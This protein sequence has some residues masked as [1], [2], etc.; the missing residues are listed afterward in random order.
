MKNFLLGLLIFFGFSANAQCVDPDLIDPLAI[1]PFIF[2]PVCGCDGNTYSNSCVAQATGGVTSWV[3]GECVAGGGCID[4]SL[5]DPDAI[6]IGVFAPVCGCDGITYSNSCWA[7]VTGGNTSWTDG[8]CDGGGSGCIDETLINP[9]ADCPQI[10]SKVCGCDDV[11]YTNSCWAQATGG[12]TQFAPGACAGSTGFDDCTDLTGLDF[13]VCGAIL[14][15]GIVEGTCT[16]ISGCSYVS[17]Q[18]D[19]AGAFYNTMEDCVFACGDGCFDESLINENAVCNGFDPVCGCDNVTYINAC[20]AENYGGLQSWTEGACSCPDPEVID[21]TSPCITIYDPV[22]GCNG[23][24]YDNDCDAWYGFGITEW[25]Q[26]ACEAGC[27]DIGDIDFGECD[28]PLGIMW[29]GQDCTMLSGCDWTVD[30]VD[31]SPYFFDSLAE[32][33]SACGDTLC[34]DPSIIDPTIICNTVV[35]PVCGCDSVTYSNACAAMNWYGVLQWTEGP[36]DTTKM[37]CIDPDLIDPLVLC[38]DFFEPV[39]GCDSMLYQNDCIAMYHNGVSTLSNG[40]CEETN[41]CV[42]QDQID[43][44]M[45]CPEVWDPVCGCDSITYGNSCDAFFY[46]GIQS[47]TPGECDIPD[48][49]WQ[50]EGMTLNVSPNPFRDQFVLSLNEQT[51]GNLTVLD[52]AGREVAAMRVFPGRNTVELGNTPSGLYILYLADQNG[53]VMTSKVV[54]R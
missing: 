8:E 33:A 13:G 41:V 52:L 34:I 16:D 47:W 4:T 40:P 21:L 2:A 51:A 42:D 37:D 38:A 53:F 30:D 31:Y 36:C 43:L 19:Y 50:V 26:G 12:V 27:M 20:A 1:C 11:T 39:C 14:G 25:T 10:I 23:I 17:N 28:M 46:A 5:I 6:C 9:N 54:K 22:C 15:V 44:T 49:I 35:D 18:V 3:D 45:G 32:C 24:T 29:D 7:Q 48:A